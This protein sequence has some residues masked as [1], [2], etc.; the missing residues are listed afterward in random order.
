LVDRI[1]L[2]WSW[3]RWPRLM[4]CSATADLSGC[5]RRM[6]GWCSLTLVSME[7][8]VCPCQF[9]HIRRVCCTRLES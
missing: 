4:L 2:Y 3:M 9:D 6:C 7:R 8:P 1:L 5:S